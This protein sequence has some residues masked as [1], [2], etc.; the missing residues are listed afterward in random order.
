MKTFALIAVI[1]GAALLAVA[2]YSAEQIPIKAQA[3]FFEYAKNSP[4]NSP[5]FPEA[6]MQ[7]HA[8]RR[9]LQN[10]YL[11]ATGLILLFVG[12]QALCCDRSKRS[13]HET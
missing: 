8:Q 10:F 1:A 3:D 6:F 12:V 2:F 9:L 4:L 5:G 7:M 13:S 11:G